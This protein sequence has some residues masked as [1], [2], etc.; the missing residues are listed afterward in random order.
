[1]KSLRGMMNPM[2]IKRKELRRE[3]SD[4]FDHINLCINSRHG[5]IGDPSIPPNRFHRAEDGIYD[6]FREG[7][8]FK[9]KVIEVDGNEP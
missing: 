7:R 2:N 9:V 8:W 6:I 5:E 1:M 4:L 3:I